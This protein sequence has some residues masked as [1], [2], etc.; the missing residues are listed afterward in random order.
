MLAFQ[1][2]FLLRVLALESGNFR[3]AVLD[4]PFGF[5][6]RL[7]DFLLGFNQCFFFLRLILLLL[8]ADADKPR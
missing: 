2:L 7:E 1:G 6:F 4:F 5:I 3:T 8:P